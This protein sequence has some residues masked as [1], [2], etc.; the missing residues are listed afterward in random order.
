MDI[1]R[2]GS[3]LAGLRVL[4]LTRVLA[5]PHCGRMLVDLGAEVVKIEPPDGDLTRF[6][7]PR[8]GSLATYFVQQNAG[9]KCMSIDL[10]T[11]RGAELF[12][13]LARRSDVVV[14]NYRAGVMDRLGLGPDV[15]MTAN[16]R[17]IYASITGYG[18][19]GPW[20][21]RRAY[22]TVIGAESGL[23]RMQG[24]AR[25]GL[26]SNDPWSHAD[27]YTALETTTAILAALYQRERTGRGE[28]IDV[29]MAE[30]MLYVN[31]HAHDELFDGP[32][33]PQW[34]RSFRPGDYPILRVADGTIVV[35]SGHPAER[36]TF[37]IMVSTMGRP[38][39]LTDAR[40]T[41]VESRRR[42]FDDLCRIME[43]WARTIPDADAFESRCA[44]SGLAVGVVRSVRELA[45]S[46]WARA[47]GAIVEVPDRIGGF[48]R[49]PN[50]PWHFGRGRVGVDGEPRYRGEDN[51]LVLSSVLGLGNAEIDS[52]EASG[53]LSSRVPKAR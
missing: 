49:V 37:E 24:D 33:D 44:E 23:T 29:S 13:E 21:H 36:G 15:L 12:V 16:P 22:A 28:R 17:L 14:E 4:D 11:L 42:H 46:E 3:P 30:T 10:A 31:E 51:R 2:P 32:V 43:D 34:I 50:S 45:E 39:L 6:S 5:G 41:D 9:K 38:E 53:V 52:L 26:Y 35:I 47:R 19:D 25:G 27:T 48:V 20:V 8:V 40:F 18:A 1:G 7:S